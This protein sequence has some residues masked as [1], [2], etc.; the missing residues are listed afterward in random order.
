[1]LF[2]LFFTWVLFLPICRLHPWWFV[3]YLLRS[4]PPR[5]GPRLGSIRSLRTRSSWLRLVNPSVAALGVS[6]S[7]PASTSRS[8]RCWANIASCSRAGRPEPSIDP[9]P[10]RKQSPCK[11]FCGE[12]S[13]SR[14]L[15]SKRSRGSR[16][17]MDKI[18]DCVHRQCAFSRDHRTTLGWSSWSV[19]L[20]RWPSSRL[21]PFH[22]WTSALSTA[23][24]RWRLTAVQARISTYSQVCRSRS[25][26]IVA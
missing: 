10:K 21:K 14:I 22:L 19:A 18:P 25:L 5:L 8:R 24:E 16:Q 23:C 17:Y 11:V 13:L 15:W 2:A 6:Q 9:D 26:R 7:L 1:M 12:V 20:R 4:H 3:K